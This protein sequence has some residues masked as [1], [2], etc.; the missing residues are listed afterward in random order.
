[1]AAFNRQPDLLRKKV[2]R[3]MIFIGEASDPAFIEYNVGLDVHAFRRIIESGLPVDWV[4]CFDG[5]LWQNHGKASYWVSTQAELLGN[6]TK[7]VLNY[8]IYALTQS[9]E[10]PIQFLVRPITSEQANGILGP[11]RNLWCT[12]IF[13]DLA[14]MK[15]RKANDRYFLADQYNTNGSVVDLFRFEEIR[16][17]V[18]EKGVV[19]TRPD[20]KSSVRRFRILDEAAYP[21]IMGHVTARLLSDLGK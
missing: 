2:A 21:E 11:D 19:T 15:I 14:G 8:F 5:G 12:A 1:V 7:K 17:S 9:K 16:C 13:G 3:L 18:D 6:V 4:P 10:D 20:G